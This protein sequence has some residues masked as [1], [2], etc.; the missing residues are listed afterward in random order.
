MLTAHPQP[1]KTLLRGWAR[2]DNIWNRR[3]AILAQ[4]RSRQA[5]D[6]KL[7]ANVIEPFS[8]ERE[9][10]LRKGIGSPTAAS[11]ASAGAKR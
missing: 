2:S 4:L 11:P 5:T 9:F 6:R 10:F 3:T 1:T 7:L 8:G